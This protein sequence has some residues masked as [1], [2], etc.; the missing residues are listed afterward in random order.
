MVRLLPDCSLVRC[1][2]G[3]HEHPERVQFFQP[4]HLVRVMLGKHCELQIQ[5]ELVIGGDRLDG[6]ADRPVY[7]KSVLALEPMPEVRLADAVGEL[8]H[9]QIL[10]VV[11]RC[12]SWG[13]T[14]SRTCCDCPDLVVNR[15][16]VLVGP[17]DDTLVDLVELLDDVRLRLLEILLP[18]AVSIVTDPTASKAWTLSAAVV[19]VFARVLTSTSA[20]AASTLASSSSHLACIPPN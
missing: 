8:T 5:V 4:L 2:L 7:L 19:S 9:N 3:L 11:L 1:Y 14:A 20:N 18:V 16:G 15:L 12:M 6:I 13:R 10:S 17:V